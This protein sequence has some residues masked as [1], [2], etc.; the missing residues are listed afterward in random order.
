MKNILF[1]IL[2]LLIFKGVFPQKIIYVFGK[3]NVPYTH[4]K[5]INTG[6]T[7]T[8]DDKGV[9]SLFVDLKKCKGLFFSSIGYNDTTVFF[10]QESISH[11]TLFID[12]ALSKK[13]YLLNEVP[14][15][16][17]RYFF[18]SKHPILDIEF[19]TNNKFLLLL[20]TSPHTSLLSIIDSTGTLLKSV[21]IKNHYS[22]FHFDCFN[23]IEL[24]SEDT[25]L[26]LLI[27]TNDN[28]FV[29]DTFMYQQFNEKLAPVQFK[30]NH[31]YLLRLPIARDKK[32][33]TN[34]QNKK[35]NLYI[36]PENSKN[37]KRKIIYSYFDKKSFLIAN[38]YLSE[39]FSLYHAKTPENEN[40]I[41][42][43]VWD[44]NIIK[45]LNG[46]HYLQRLI[47]WYLN[48]ETTPVLVKAFKTD[49]N[50][51]FINLSNNILL[52]YNQNIVLKDSIDLI[53]GNNDYKD[54]LQDRKNENI[55]L[56][57]EKNGI[58]YLEKIDLKTGQLKPP[59]KACIRPFPDILKIYDN[60]S[61]SVY[62]DRA[63]HYNYIMRK[64]LEN[65]K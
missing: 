62:Y 60:H 36:I 24:V 38:S 57:Y 51:F 26:Q 33:V 22:K 46:D 59:V 19:I 16:A 28:I 1:L 31:Y 37:Q 43:G 48:F 64:S 34:Y 40:I 13:T 21:N 45:L 17:S 55:Y 42:A 2:C 30:I 54:I 29:V 41:K 61:Y 11:D 53:V 8:S 56:L 3:V 35:V 32:Y 27:D 23:N 50:L 52:R 5:L 6:I 14:I 4:I 47:A 12:V 7:T 20:S 10:N 44:G 25:C 65:E 15:F 49:D 63:Q 39:I 58:N 9:F 18:K